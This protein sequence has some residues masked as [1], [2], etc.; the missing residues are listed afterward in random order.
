MNS[1]EAK[2]QTEIGIW[3]KISPI[4][5]NKILDACDEGL[6]EIVINKTYIS[7]DDFDRLIKLGYCI[8][9]NET[10]KFDPVYYISWK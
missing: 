8:T 9:F 5:I 4:I 6:Y 1:E 7:E 10:N 2:K 3:L